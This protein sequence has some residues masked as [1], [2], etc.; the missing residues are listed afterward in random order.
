MGHPSGLGMLKS[1]YF[2]TYLSSW[3]TGDAEKHVYCDIFELMGRSSGLG[4]L[5]IMYFATYLRSW[6]TQVDWEC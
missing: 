2:V 6:G 1:M 3:G 5:K 4:T